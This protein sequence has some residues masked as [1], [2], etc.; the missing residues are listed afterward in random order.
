MPLRQIMHRRQSPDL[1]LALA[2][3]ETDLDLLPD[4]AAQERAAQRR[5]HRDRHLG[6]AVF[7]LDELPERECVNLL[8]LGIDVLDGHAR[9]EADAV[10][11]DVLLAH[12]GEFREPQ[13]Q[14]VHA[15][16]RELLA[17]ERGLVFGVLAQ[18]AVSAR[19]L[20]LLRYHK[21]DLVVQALD[22]GLE[23]LLEAFDHGWKISAIR[24]YD[25]TL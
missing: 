15:R 5:C 11:R 17:L 14:M 4:F 8:L 1:P 9:A 22:F 20:D 6:D 7:A 19:F 21:R 16:L 18:I 2:H 13:A 12:V 10:A 23:F 3:G 25:A 24:R